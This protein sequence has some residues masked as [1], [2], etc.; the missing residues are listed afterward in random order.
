MVAQ[1]VKVTNPLSFVLN[2]YP[3]FSRSI[4]ASNS[5]LM[6]YYAPYP[7]NFTAP[8]IDIIFLL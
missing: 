4:L 7:K 6:S 2:I 1:K 3:Y 8:A 5:R